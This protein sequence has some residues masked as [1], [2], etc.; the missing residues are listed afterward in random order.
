MKINL[1][2]TRMHTYT[3][4]HTH[5]HKRTKLKYLLIIRYSICLN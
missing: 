1:Q 2:Q 3:H 5:T 4:T